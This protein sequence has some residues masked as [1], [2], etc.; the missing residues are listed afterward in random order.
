MLSNGG[1]GAITERMT[2][3]SPHLYTRNNARNM[4]TKLHWESSTNG[5]TDNPFIFN[6]ITRD[7]KV[8]SKG[9]CDFQ[10]GGGVV[11]F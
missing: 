3:C 9:A 6:Q 7:H 10:G 2:S 4:G 1:E 5:A 8:I 11:Q